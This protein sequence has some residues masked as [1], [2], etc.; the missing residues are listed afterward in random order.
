MPLALPENRTWYEIECPV[1]KVGFC[2]F[3]KSQKFCSFPCKDK[4]KKYRLDQVEAS[5]KKIKKIKCGKCEKEFIGKVGYNKYCRECKSRPSP[6]GRPVGR[7]SMYKKK[8]CKDLIKH[9]AKGMSYETFGAT[10]DVCKSTV[11]GWEAHKEF[12][13]AKKIGFQ[14]CQ[15]F[16]EELGIHGAS[17]RMKNFSAAAYIYNCKNRFRKSDTYGHDPDNEKSNTFNFNLAYDPKALKDG[18]EN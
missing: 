12:L 7:P 10:I 14:K 15:A 3:I 16:W 9:M 1:C 18:D 8:Y 5:R 6:T 2:T 17:G 4:G 11:Y 13:E